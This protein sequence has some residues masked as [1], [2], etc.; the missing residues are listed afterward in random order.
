VAHESLHPGVAGF[1][2][3]PP[4]PQLIRD[5][6]QLVQLP[7]E[8]ELADAIVSLTVEVL[9]DG[10]I[11][12]HACLPYSQLLA[13]LIASVAHQPGE[14]QDSMSEQQKH[15]THSRVRP[16]GCEVMYKVRHP[17]LKEQL[18]FRHSHVA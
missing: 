10:T 1:R 8:G 14:A 12:K 11:C 16:K 17:H 18:H 3:E 7:G 13:V 6:L 2:G 9:G 5:V 15:Q 4:K